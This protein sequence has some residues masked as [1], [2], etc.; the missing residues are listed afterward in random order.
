MYNPPPAGTIA[1]WDKF[2]E[3]TTYLWKLYDSIAKE[4]KP[5]N[6][7]RQSWRRHT[8][9]GRLNPGEICEWFQCDNQGRGGDDT[10][11]WAV[12][13]AVQGAYA[14]PCKGKCPPT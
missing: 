11:I 12:R 6:S 9:H 13:A 3:R 1:Y 8:Q 4:K 5:V 7:I 2:N 14:T 10:P